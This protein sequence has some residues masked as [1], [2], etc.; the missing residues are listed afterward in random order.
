MQP[1]RISHIHESGRQSMSAARLDEGKVV[2]AIE[3]K[4]RIGAF[5]ERHVGRVAPEQLS[6]TIDLSRIALIVGIVFLHYGMY[7]NFRVSPFGGVSV[8]EHEVAMFVNS[9]LLFFFFSVVPLLSA[10]SGWLFFA[11]LKDPGAD[12]DKALR[13]RIRKRWRSLYLP[14]VLWNLLYVAVLMALFAY[15]PEHPLLKSLNVDFREAGL[16]EFL[17]AIFAITHHPLAFQFWFVRDLFLTVLLSP[18]L[19]LLLRKAP[20]TGAAG[21]CVV[22]LCNYDLAIFFRPDVLF[23]FYL[24][25]L[26]RMRGARLGISWQATRWLIGM[27]I[28]L[29]SVRALVPYVMDESTVAL[30]L[31]TRGMRLMGVLACWGFFLKL[32]AGPLGAR[33]SHWGA[34]AFFLYAMHFPLMAQIKL[35]LW[36]AMPRINDFWMV[37]HYLASVTA[38]IILALCTAVVLSRHAPRAFAL[39]NGGRDADRNDRAAPPVRTS[40]RGP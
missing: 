23:F 34:M 35:I 29:V 26:L 13:T 3:G 31:V 40:I 37:T 12:A 28:A 6:L 1:W 4:S 25:G 8:N 32:A 21:L 27:Y 14:L 18:L 7:P 38:T 15:A 16:R 2:M 5:L 10:I 20:L 19:W 22:W 11:F 33:L 17:D 30:T 39:L 9:F 36:D 24:G